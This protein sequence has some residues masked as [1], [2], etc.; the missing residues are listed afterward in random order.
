LTER[1]ANDARGVARILARLEQH[2]TRKAAAFSA[3]LAPM[4]RG[5]HGCRIAVLAALAAAAVAASA[6]AGSP[7]RFTGP[8]LTHPA[9]PPDFALRDQNGR[10]IRL[11]AER[12]NV[13]LLTFLYTNCPDLCPLTAARINAALGTLGPARKRVIALAVTVDPKGDTPAAVKAFVRG[14]RLRPQFHYLTGSRK[15]LAR[16]W[17]AYHV[18]A[19]R[20]P[21]DD[22]DHTLYTLV[23]DRSGKGRVLFDSRASV[24]ALA[25]D[26][27]LLL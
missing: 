25:H 21:G 22:V 5:V 9:P 12:G 23:V 2:L 10:L 8:T 4:P 6:A 3:T 16:I 1:R 14:H 20:H 19:V 27:R 17:R 18:T 26:I 15:A 13:V 11:S 7:P 24:L